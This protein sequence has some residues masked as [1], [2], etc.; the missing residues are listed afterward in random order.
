[1]RQHKKNWHYF[2]E[3][4]LLSGKPLRFCTES[5]YLIWE[6][7]EFCCNGTRSISQRNLFP[8]CCYAC[9]SYQN[10]GINSTTKYLQMH[11]ISLVIHNCGAQWFSGNQCRLTARSSKFNTQE[12]CMLSMWNSGYSGYLPQAKNMH[13][14]DVN[15]SRRYAVPHSTMGLRKSWSPTLSKHCQKTLKR[16]VAVCRAPK[17]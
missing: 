4:C 13:Q 17:G 15:L 12:L 9:I 7:P 14:V 10:N 16:S 1:M 11:V 6:Y 5:H 8:S 2:K 3:E